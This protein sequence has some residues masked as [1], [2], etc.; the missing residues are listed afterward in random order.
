MHIPADQSTIDDR[1]NRFMAR[2]TTSFWADI[3]QTV[4]VRMAPRNSKNTDSDI[5]YEPLDWNRHSGTSRR[6]KLQ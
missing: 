3:S 6:S 5:S 4:A 1:I 2:K